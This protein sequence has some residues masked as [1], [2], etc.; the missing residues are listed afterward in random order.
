MNTN[1]WK[2]GA[3]LLMAF[4]LLI[5][6]EARAQRFALSMNALEYVNL[7]TFNAEAS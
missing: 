7:C 1:Q 3:V 5:A 6:Q 2:K 4:L